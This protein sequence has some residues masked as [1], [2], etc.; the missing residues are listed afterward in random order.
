[1]NLTPTC[2]ISLIA[3]DLF[4]YLKANAMGPENAIKIG[5]WIYGDID[6][7][8]GLCYRLSQP[9]RVVELAKNELQGAGIPI[10]GNG[11]GIFIAR[12]LE[13]AQ[14][15][16]AS[17]QRRIKSM[18]YLYHMAVAPLIAAGADAEQLKL[19]L[20]INTRSL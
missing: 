18:A 19:G 2:K 14:P 9:R 5:Q 20:D 11:N 1:M 15:Y 8:R 10:F 12:N 16:I 13:E 4:E 3:Y 17:M 6:K 7:C